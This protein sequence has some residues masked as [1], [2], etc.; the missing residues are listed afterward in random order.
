MNKHVI[1]GIAVDETITFFV[2]KPLYSTLF[3]HISS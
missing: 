2:V 1:P 3:S